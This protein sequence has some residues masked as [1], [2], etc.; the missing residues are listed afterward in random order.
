[1]TDPMSF[2]D[3]I[4]EAVRSKIDDIKYTQEKKSWDVSDMV[5]IGWR[6]VLPEPPKNTSNRTMRELSYLSDLTKNL[7]KSQESLVMLVDEEP[8][9][10]FE[11]VI[12]KS[13][14]DRSPFDKVWPIVDPVIMNLKYQYNR[15][16]PAQLAGV[17]KK[18]INVKETKT[19]QTPAYPSGHTAYAAIAA[20]LYADMY[21]ELSSDI[22]RQVGLCGHARCLQGVH[23]PSDNE[24]SMVI[25]G[26]VW[27][28]VRYELFPNLP[29]KY[30]Q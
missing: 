12:G 28:N 8:L 21:P 19:H 2:S 25:A 17:F 9:L 26:A 30:E 29:K 11:S 1:M 22:F 16:R 15:P 14:F 4:L 24:A 6:N 18:E 5:T 3:A 23:F 10:L 20:Y 13:R 7:T 27:E